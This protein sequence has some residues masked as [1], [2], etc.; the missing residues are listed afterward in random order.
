[1]EAEHRLPNAMGWQEYSENYENC[2]SLTDDELREFHRKTEQLRRNNFGKNGFLQSQSS[3]LF[4]PWRSTC[5]AEFEDSDMQTSSCETSD[6]DA[7]KYAYK[8]LTVKSD[9]VNSAC[10]LRGYTEEI[11]LFLF[12]FLC[13][14]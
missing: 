8:M 1:M 3:S 6:D 7:W 13:Y 9:P 5:R 12:L 14:C 10:V 4:S 11:V 2:L